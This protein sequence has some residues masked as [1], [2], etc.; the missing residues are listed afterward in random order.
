MLRKSVPDDAFRSAAMMFGVKDIER[1]AEF[2][3]D[4]LGFSVRGVWKDIGH[5]AIVRRG[6]P[7]VDMMGE[8]LRALSASP[9]AQDKPVKG[10]LAA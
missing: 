2:Y 9:G 1:A 4:R 6:E 8:P 10:V 7:R 3:R 5:Y